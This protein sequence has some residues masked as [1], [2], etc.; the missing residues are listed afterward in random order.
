VPPF[1]G[2]MRLK[3]KVA[4]IAGAGSSGPGMGIGRATSI[5][6]AQEGAKVVCADI[7]E[8]A[9]KETLRMVRERG[10][11]GIVVQGDFTRSED[12]RRIVET[13]VS[14]YGKLDILHNVVGIATP[15]GILETSEEDWDAV[16]TT[17]LKSIFLMS[18]YTVPHMIR[19]GGGVIINTSS[20]AGLTGHPSANYSATKA[21]IINLTRSMAIELAEHRIRVNCIAPGFLDTPMVAPIMTEERRRIL[22]WMIPLGRLGTAWDAAYGALYLASDEASYVTGITLVID[23]GLLAGRGIGPAKPPGGMV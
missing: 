17:N 18:K 21:A 16:V 23:G 5:L 12:A 4:L 15:F 6:F 3:G 13:A 2:G 7:N 8:E 19:G 22:E 9:A 1:L 14:T 20:A 10:G 11:E